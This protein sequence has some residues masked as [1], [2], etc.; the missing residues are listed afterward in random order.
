MEKQRAQADEVGDAGEEGLWHS[1][2]ML[3]DCPHVNGAA[4]GVAV[5][6]KK[7]YPSP[8][9]ADCGDK[10]ES[11]YC[12][13]CGEVAC[14]RYINGHAARHFKTSSHPL[15]LSSV[16]LSVWCYACDSYVSNELLFPIINVLH[17]A[18]FGESHPQYKGDIGFITDD[19]H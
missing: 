18:K 14:S 4:L 16:D 8:G 2:D 7:L 15:F 13:Y 1:V 17:E 5:L 12:L 11:W 3:H 19:M 10:R 9:C 6:L